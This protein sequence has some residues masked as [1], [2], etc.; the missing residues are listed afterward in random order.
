M[1]ISQKA[2]MGR[3]WNFF[4][5]LKLQIINENGFGRLEQFFLLDQVKG[6]CEP[7]F[8]WRRAQAGHQI[9]VDKKSSQKWI[10]FEGLQNLWM[11][12]LSLTRSWWA[13]APN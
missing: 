6:H 9:L 8:L 10:I 4:G 7:S 5:G 11:I 3:I 12:V 13:G 2:Q 1:Q